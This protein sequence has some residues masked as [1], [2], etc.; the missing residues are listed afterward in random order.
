MISTGPC[1]RV[2]HA[3]CPCSLGEHTRASA[4]RCTTSSPVSTSTKATTVKREARKR[5]LPIATINHVTLRPSDWSALFCLLTVLSSKRQKFALIFP[6]FSRAQEVD[7]QNDEREVT[8]R[9]RFG[10]FSTPSQDTHMSYS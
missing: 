1:E 4:H 10:Y 9:V 5:E 6:K 7:A 8:S 3:L 2:M